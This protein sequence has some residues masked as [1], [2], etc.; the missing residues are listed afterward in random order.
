MVENDSY[1]YRKGI[2]WL[3]K[4]WFGYIKMFE[5]ARRFQW[6][7]HCDSIEVVPGAHVRYAAPLRTSMLHELMGRSAVGAKHHME[8]S[9]FSG[10]AGQPKWCVCLECFMTHR[11]SGSV[12]V[13][14][15]G[16]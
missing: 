8:R 14:A 6:F 5:I 11:A 10:C 3:K 7:L 13:P 2:I 16:Q 9:N 12:W 15:W 4:I 1:G